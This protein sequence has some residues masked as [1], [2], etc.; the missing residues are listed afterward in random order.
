M[1]G[2]V[3]GILVVSIILS[4]IPEVSKFAA[5]FGIIALAIVFVI[6][7]VRVVPQQN[8]WIVERLGK[9]HETLEPGLNVIIPFVDR[10]AYKHSLKEVPL[11]VPEQICITRDNTQLSV[12]GILYYQV[13][14]PHQASYG[15]ENYVIA[16]TQDRK[17]TRLNSSHT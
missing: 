1:L 14:D 2:K 9:Y 7:G 11:D 8:A 15:S 17:S 6:E 16:I 3:I 12:D 10:V 4:T 5:P 13:I